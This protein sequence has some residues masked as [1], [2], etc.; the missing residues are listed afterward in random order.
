[1]KIAYLGAGTWGFCLASL[2]GAKGFEVCLWSANPEFVK[3]LLK[4]REH[5]K[6]PRHKA[7]DNVH[8]TS[9]LKLALQD[10]DVLI[11]SVTSKG[12]RPVF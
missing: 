10:A 8:I 4:K 3:H 5:P 6:L 11:E 12:I 1:M 7:P 2:L 9:D